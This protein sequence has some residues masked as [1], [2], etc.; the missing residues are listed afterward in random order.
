MEHLDLARCLGNTNQIL[1]SLSTF[2]QQDAV[3][4]SSSRQILEPIMEETSE[5]EELAQG[6]WS[7]CQEQQSSLWSSTES[8]TGSVLRIELMKEVDARSERDFAC[9]AKRP[10]HSLEPDPG[11]SLEDSVQMRRPH[12]QDFESHNSLERILV[13]DACAR[14]SCGSQGQRSS[15]GSRRGGSFDDYNSD[16]DSFHSLSR[17]SSL[18][19]FEFLERQ[20]T[21]QE[22]HQSMNSLGNSSPSLF[23]CELNVATRS[24]DSNPESRRGSASSLSLMKRFESSDCRLHQTYYEL[25]KLNFEDHQQLFCKSLHQTELKS[26]SETCSSSS[27]SSSSDSSSHSLVSSCLGIGNAREARNQGETASRRMPPNSAENLSEDSGYCEPRLLQLEKSKSIPKN[28]DKLCEEEEKLLL[29]EEGS[30]FSRNSHDL[31]HPKIEQTA[32]IALTPCSP[33]SPSSPPLSINSFPER[34]CSQS[35]LDLPLTSPTGSAVSTSSAASFT[36]LRNSLPDIREPRGPLSLAIGELDSLYG[37]VLATSSH[38]RSHSRSSAGSSSPTTNSLPNELQQLGRRR[39]PRNIRPNQQNYNS[40]SSVSS[41]SSEAL[42][43]ERGESRDDFFLECYSLSKIRRSCSLKERPRRAVSAASTRY[44]N[45]SYQNLTLLDYTEKRPLKDQ[46]NHKRSQAEVMSDGVYE[47][48]ICKGNF[49]LDEISKIYDKNVSIL[50]DKPALEE[51]LQPP[52]EDHIS[53]ARE[54]PSVQHLQLTIKQPPRQK[55]STRDSKQCF[56]KT[57]DQDPTNLRT[58][59]AQSLEQCHFDVQKIHAPGYQPTILQRPLPKRRFHSAKQRSLVSSTPNLSVCDKGGEDPE[60]E[61]YVNSAHTSMHHLPKPL[62]ILLPAGSRH[63]FGKEVSFCPVVSKYCWQEQSSEEPFEDQCR[64]SEG[65]QGPSNDDELLDNADATVVHNTKENENI[66]A[67][68]DQEQS[69]C[70]REPAIEESVATEQKTKIA[71][72]ECLHQKTEAKT[73]PGNELSLSSAISLEP[74]IV[75]RSSFQSAHQASALPLSL[76]LPVLSEP[77]TNRAFHILY[78]SQQVLEGYEGPKI[79][80]M[81]PA[82]NLSRTTDKTSKGF[83]SR[84]THGLRFSLRR[85]KKLQKLEQRDQKG[86]QN[87]STVVL[88]SPIKYSMPSNGNSK[89]DDSVHIPLK[90]PRSSQCTQLH[91]STEAITASVHSSRQLE[92]LNETQQKVVT[93][94]PPLP[95]LAP[96]NGNQAY[97]SIGANAS[98]TTT[99]HTEAL[100]SAE[101]RQYEPRMQGTESPSTAIGAQKTHKVKQLGGNGLAAK[102]TVVTAVPVTVSPVE[103]GGKMG[104]METNLD[105]HETVISGK[106]RS[107][108]DITCN[109]LSLSYKRYIVKRLNVTSAAHD[110]G[111]VDGEAIIGGVQIASVRRPHKSMEF[112]LDKKNQKNILPPENELQ[113]SHDQYPAALS[114]HQL[115]VQA[116]L[117]RLNIP[118][119]FRHYNKGSGPAPDGTAALTAGGYRTGNFTR[120][121]TQESGRW[122]GLNSKTTSLSSLACQRSDRSPLLMSPSAHSHHGGQSSIYSCSSA[123]GPGQALGQTGVSATR[124]STSHLNSTQTSPSASQRGSF[125]RGAPINSSFMSVASSSGVLRNSYR[126][127]YLGWRS[128]EKLSHRTPHERLAISLLAHRTTPSPTSTP[129]GTRPLQSETAEVQSSIKEVTSAIVHYVNDQQQSQDQ[130][131]RSAS[132]NSRIILLPCNSL[133][134]KF[135]TY[136]DNRT[137]VKKEINVQS[138]NFDISILLFVLKFI[139]KSSPVM[140]FSVTNGKVYVR[141]LFFPPSPSGKVEFLRAPSIHTPSRSIQLY[142]PL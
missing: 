40:K 27:S 34:A 19:Q 117:Q 66:A 108:M 69:H 103:E 98:A 67:L 23:N 137:N 135:I 87:Q 105:T 89:W 123:A 14:D 124:W 82:S 15:L 65:E 62:G 13:I 3:Y 68:F 47:Q 110:E 127:P 38:R 31:C 114:E 93:G 52:S 132:P 138:L 5:D 90:P 140:N 1:N 39:R 64:S 126:Q 50:T 134:T 17:S 106:T 18:V 37:F 10:R 30:P 131:S 36:W 111:D 86:E 83:I 96:R 71:T 48:I 129:N 116:S 74:C 35:K 43:L 139:D 57:F 133:L 22:Q 29:L 72:P 59:Y 88:A 7:G 92:H 119:W 4:L 128:T 73:T 45:A 56:G 136:V 33:C 53:N 41:S 20:F 16:N 70:F 112:L 75:A 2:E 32:N 49:L 63:S 104:L 55:R 100:L 95:K 6:T 54:E 12:R 122:Q 120:K 25:N 102:Q 115:R 46:R 130:R 85:K 24:S 84:L 58:M 79:C 99:A 78:A 26:D 142:S 28:F 61:I 11:H 80:E 107:L 76:T 97:V 44:L 125:A 141:A 91:N 101:R 60:D 42:N 109:P 113:K 94:K 118:D 121:P 8:E 21:L 77:P 9:P 51:K 81:L